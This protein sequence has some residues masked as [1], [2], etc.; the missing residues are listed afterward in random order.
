VTAGS[1]A[2]AGGAVGWNA[3][4]TGIIGGTG[5]ATTAAG[6]NGS[7]WRG[8]AGPSRDRLESCEAAGLQ[9]LFRCS[10]LAPRQGKLPFP[11]WT[12]GGRFAKRPALAKAFSDFRPG[13]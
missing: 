11:C 13:A 7:D 5:M 3:A 6:R 9:R 12:S 10:T 4:L 8:R 2:I 1:A